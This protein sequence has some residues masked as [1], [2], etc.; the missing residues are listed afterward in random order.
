[1]DRRRFLLTSLAGAL[2]GPR[3]AAGQPIDKIR[4]IGHLGGASPAAIAPWLET[5]RRALTELGWR[6]GQNITI[7]NRSVEGRF[8]RLPNAAAELVRLPVDLIIAGTTPAAQA[9]RQATT[10]IPI[11]TTV[12]SD[13]V[14]S[15]LAASLARPGGNVTGLTLLAGPEIVGK[16]LELLKAAVPALS[17]LAVLWN[18]AQTAH[19]PL[20][21]QA[22]TAARAIGCQLRL[23]TA[24]SP[25]EFDGAFVTMAQEQADALLV[26]ADPMFFQQRAILANLAAKNRLP[27]MYG[28]REHVEAGGLMTY[29]ASI[30][31]LY[32]RAALYVDKIFKGAKPADLPIEQPS[33]FELVIN[34]KTAKALGLTIP[35]SLLA[36]ADQVIE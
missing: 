19:P 35:P 14:G 16:Y 3:A 6:E 2:A 18:P 13:P 17:R 27:A 9:A 10:T 36:R 24:R 32:R 22:E 8:E 28:L 34:L 25:A 4:R 7:E 23:V 21:R 31:D 29:A 1:V 33:T 20:I 15:G 26:L 11:V 12:V 5:L 30:H